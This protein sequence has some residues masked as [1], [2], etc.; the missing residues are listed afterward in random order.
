MAEQ[1]PWDLIPEKLADLYVAEYAKRN[2]GVDRPDDRDLEVLKELA[3]ATVASVV[4]WGE[5]NCEE[6]E[7][8]Q[9]EKFRPSRRRECRYCW[10]DLRQEEKP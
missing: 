10:R 6:Y 7:H 8:R 5:E 9:K 4:K 3:K 2:T 1:K